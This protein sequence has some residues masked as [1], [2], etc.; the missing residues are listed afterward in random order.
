M[1]KALKIAAVGLAVAGAL[2]FLV[3]S[4]RPDDTLV[5]ACKDGGIPW[6][7]GVREMDAR[8]MIVRETERSV[9][10]ERAQWDAQSSKG[11]TSVALMVWCMRRQ[12]RGETT[13]IRDGQSGELLLSIHGGKIAR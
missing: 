6:Q 12:M 4:S 13:L 2:Y 1:S 9:Y 3:Q 8:G 10:V 7:R 11:K 5:N